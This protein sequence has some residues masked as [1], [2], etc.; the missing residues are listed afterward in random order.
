[1]DPVARRGRSPVVILVVLVAHL[2]LVVALLR[3]VGVRLPAPLEEF[4][5]VW[6]LDAD[7][8]R[9]AMTEP[10]PGS[11]EPTASSPSPLVPPTASDAAA[12]RPDSGGAAG[13]VA[14]GATPGELRPP[15][16]DA[17]AATTRGIDWF[18][19]GEKVARDTVARAAEAARPARAPFRSAPDK[20]PTNSIFDP[21]RRR[22]GTSEKT[23]D[24]ESIFWINENCYVT[25][26]SDSLLQKDLHDM[27]R[28]MTR[29]MVPLG[30]RKARGDLL[31]HLPN[32][33][34]KG[35]PHDPT[36]PDSRGG[37]GP[38]GMP[39]PLPPAADEDR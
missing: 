10:E 28:G 23:A 16:R 32:H 2:A 36:L 5:S 18:R 11:V 37:T 17:S 6:L 30:K 9:P 22:T 25:T 3:V 26:G 7:E 12:R 19:V 1:M 13:E 20:A 24:G 31:D 21:G 38:G 4:A 39:E 14:R 33:E 29:C 8:L 34:R 35:R 27:H 15:S